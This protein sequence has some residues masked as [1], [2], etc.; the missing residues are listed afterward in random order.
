MSKKT[1]N[2]HPS[3]LPSYRGWYPHVYNI[4]ENTQSGV[5]LHEL[6]ESADTGKIWI[7]KKVN[8]IPTDNAKDLY[9]R[10]QFEIVKLFKKKIG[11]KLK[12]D[13]I[14]PFKQEKSI[15]LLRRKKMLINMIT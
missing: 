13:Q 7:Q 1:I 12:N 11:K 10:L 6:N 2:F 8:Q 9:K 4:I 5:T 14:K 3:L 15:L